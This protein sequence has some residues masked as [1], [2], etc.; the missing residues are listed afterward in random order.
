[1]LRRSNVLIVVL[2]A[3]SYAIAG[4]PS[5]GTV[6]ARG[7][8][9]IDNSEV[10]GSG[11]LFDGSIVETG[12]S[13]MSSAD[14]RV[15]GRTVI[16]LALDS[17][18]VLYRDH[19]VLERGK[20]EFSAANS[21]HIEAHGLVV[22]PVAQ[23][24]G[25]VSIDEGNR[26]NVAAQA[27]DLEVKSRPKQDVDFVMHPGMAFAFGSVAALAT[28][29]ISIISSGLSAPSGRNCKQQNL[30]PCCPHQSAPLC[31]PGVEYPRSQCKASQ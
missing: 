31:C 4:T 28:V 24:S 30:E 18:G 10:R 27:G 7:E 6:T 14:L 19:F 11:T 22:S 26:V 2:W 23:G 20:I 9:K 21:F 16:K 5:I 13:A 3:S 25:L 15:S 29:P 17:R 12:K 1:M 8:T